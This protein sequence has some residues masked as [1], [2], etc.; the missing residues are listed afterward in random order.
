MNQHTDELDELPEFTEEM[1]AELKQKPVDLHLGP[2]QVKKSDP[3]WY[4]KKYG[5]RPP[6]PGILAM[7]ALIVVLFVTALILFVKSWVWAVVS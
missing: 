7:D 3:N 6:G 5:P 4:V 1:L 2:A